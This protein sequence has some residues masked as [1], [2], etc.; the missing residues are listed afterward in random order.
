MKILLLGQS[1]FIGHNIEEYFNCRKSYILDKFSHEKLDVL[2]EDSVVDCLQKGKYDVVLNCLDSYAG[3][4][5]MERRLRMFMNLACHNDLYGKMIYFGTGAE[6][7]RKFPLAN[8]S[9]EDI[10]KTVPGD[11]YGLAMYIMNRIA[12]ESTNIYNL[13]LF[14]I[15]GRYEQWQTRFISNAVCKK[16]KNYPITIRQERRMSYTDVSDLCSIVEWSIKNTPNFHDYN[17]VSS[18]SFLLSE[19]A[20]IVN[21]TDGNE[22]PV[23]IARQ[24][25]FSEYTGNGDRLLHETGYKYKDMHISI[26][27]LF[28]YYR[29]NIDLIDNYSL[30]YQ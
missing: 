8:V 28:T 3:N 18:T 30:L 24:G 10:G 15:F 17:I 26:R 22:V 25:I 11:E 5:Y 7:G 4:G 1:G 20:S 19:L 27:D 12:R 16:I 21:S 14:G 9:E 23:Y 2:N 6:Y 29:D 13:R